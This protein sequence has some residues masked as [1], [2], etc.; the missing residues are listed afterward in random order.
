MARASC[1]QGR[2]EHGREQPPPAAP[3]S[4][5]RGRRWSR[6]AHSS[7]S[8]PGHEPLRHRWSTELAPRAAERALFQ[9]DQ[10]LD[11]SNWAIATVDGAA[12]TGPS[13][14]R[15]GRGGRVGAEI[16]ARASKRSAAP[17][18]R[19]LSMAFFRARRSRRARRPGR[20]RSRRGWDHPLRADRRRVPNR[21]DAGSGRWPRLR[22]ARAS[23]GL[24]QSASTGMRDGPGRP[25]TAAPLAS[26]LVERGEVRPPAR[27]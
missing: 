11:C 5:W 20:L 19:A 4:T 6:A 18:S 1:Q 10:V 16:T 23:P 12:V 26:R 17:S 8:Q 27:G 2:G 13:P 21:K 15:G 7:K 25:W 14:T 3:R 22:A 24:E 9:H